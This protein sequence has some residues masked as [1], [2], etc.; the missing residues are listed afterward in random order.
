MNAVKTNLWIL[1]GLLITIAGCKKTDPLIKDDM[2]TFQQIDAYIGSL[3]DNAD[4]PGISIAI[5]NGQ[6]VAYSKSFGL[7]NVQT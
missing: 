1:S 2:G 6:E 5:T 4:I 3:V 7:A